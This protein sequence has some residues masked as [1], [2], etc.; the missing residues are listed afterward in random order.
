MLQGFSHLSGLHH[1]VL[2]KL[3]TSRVR[4]KEF[5]LTHAYATMRLFDAHGAERNVMGI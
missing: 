1:I 2:V 4:V 3:A 5:D